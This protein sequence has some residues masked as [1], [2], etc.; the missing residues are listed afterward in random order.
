[1]K[2]KFSINRLALAF[3][4]VLLCVVLSSC[5]NDTQKNGLILTDPNTGKLYLLK[6]NVGDTYFIYE[7]QMLI[8]GKDTTWVFDK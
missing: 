7:R 4:S 1:M 2:H 3:A 8:S 6:H 5:N